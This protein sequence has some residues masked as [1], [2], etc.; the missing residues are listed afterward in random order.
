MSH[1]NPGWNTFFKSTAQFD[2]KNCLFLAVTIIKWMQRSNPDLQTFLSFEFF[3]RLFGREKRGEKCTRRWPLLFLE[4]SWSGLFSGLF[5]RLSAVRKR[6]PKMPPQKRPASQPFFLS[7][8][9]VTEYWPQ[10]YICVFP[11]P[12]EGL[13][14]IRRLCPHTKST[15]TRLDRFKLW[16][17][18]SECVELGENVQK[19]LTVTWFLRRLVTK[20]EFSKKKKIALDQTKMQ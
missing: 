13:K 14:Y 1:D 16:K 19:N 20:S 2:K 5:S 17:R 8:V 15:W 6:R 9:D 12:S 7:L 4:D 11:G 3:I 10:V 18:F